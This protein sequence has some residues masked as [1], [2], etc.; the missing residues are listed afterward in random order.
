M[1]DHFL[2]PCRAEEMLSHKSLHMFICLSNYSCPNIKVASDL[3]TDTFLI[4][5]KL[6]RAKRKIREQ[7][8]ESSS[9]SWVTPKPKII[10]KATK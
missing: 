5:F 1:V 10:S 3:S 2:L 8:N 7:I 4:A 9:K 6:T